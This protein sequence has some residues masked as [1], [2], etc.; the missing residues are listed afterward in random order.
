VLSKNVPNTVA[1]G[2][3]FV[4][5]GIECALAKA[6]EIAADLVEKPDLCN[7]QDYVRLCQWH[8]QIKREIQ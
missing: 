8:S 4:T 6:K 1:D 2:F 5:D 3:T 7:K